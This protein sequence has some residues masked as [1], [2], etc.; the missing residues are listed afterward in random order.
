L[1]DPAAL[2]KARDEFD[3]YAKSHHYKS[4]LP[5]DAK[6]PLDINE[7]LMSQYRPLMEEFYLE[8]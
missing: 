6:P 7:K 1:I 2:E 5:P 4:F 3:D 8:Q